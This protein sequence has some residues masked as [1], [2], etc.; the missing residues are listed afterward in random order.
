MNLL[1]QYFFLTEELVNYYSEL[2]SDVQHSDS[3]IHMYIYFQ[4]FSIICYYR[5]LNIVP[6]AIVNPCFLSILYMVV[7][8]CWG[9]TR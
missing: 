7:C 3:V 1:W 4:F 5:T 6:F 8:I 9:P 2:V